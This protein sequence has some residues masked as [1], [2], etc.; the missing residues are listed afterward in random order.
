LNISRLTLAPS[1]AAITN[2]MTSDEV[3]FK[4]GQIDKKI[5]FDG[6]YTAKKKDVYLNTFSFVEDA[7]DP[8]DYANDMTVYLLIDGKPVADADLKD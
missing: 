6:T 2:T 1:K 5:I 3:E 4:A 7:N 8:W